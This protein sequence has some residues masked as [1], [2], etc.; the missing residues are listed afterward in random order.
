MTHETFAIKQLDRFL[1]LGGVSEIDP[2]AFGDRPVGGS[3]FAMLDRA[4]AGKKIGDINI[5]GLSV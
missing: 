2:H 1:R 3:L 4:D 5:G